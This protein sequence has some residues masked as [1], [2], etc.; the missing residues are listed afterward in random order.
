MHTLD[1]YVVLYLTDQNDGGVNN[2]GKLGVVGNFSKTSKYTVAPFKCYA[3][4]FLV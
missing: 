1:H 3:G 4:L 2:G